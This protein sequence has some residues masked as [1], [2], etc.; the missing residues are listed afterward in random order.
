[1]R[2]LGAAAIG[3]VQVEGR[4]ELLA[5]FEPWPSETP[6]T[7][8]EAYLLACRKRD[9]DPVEAVALFDKLALERPNDPIPRIIAKRLRAAACL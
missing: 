1:L 5:V 9:L 6:P 8:R 3:L 2:R 7:W 4:E